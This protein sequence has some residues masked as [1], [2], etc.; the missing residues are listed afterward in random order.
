M[1]L[2]N[3]LLAYHSWIECGCPDVSKGAP[4]QYRDVSK[5][6]SAGRDRGMRLFEQALQFLRADGSSPLAGSRL[7]IATEFEACKNFAYGGGG[8]AGSAPTG[9]EKIDLVNLDLP[10]VAGSVDI[11][12][13][14]RDWQRSQYLDIGRLKLPVCDWGRTSKTAPPRCPSR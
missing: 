8:P 1:M 14:L 4:K 2:V 12:P 5:W 7:R 11:A 10:K 9:V 13:L 6:C 3:A